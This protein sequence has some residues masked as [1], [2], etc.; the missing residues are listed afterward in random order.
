MNVNMNSLN[1]KL[2]KLSIALS[3]FG[4]REESK[5]VIGLY[6]YAFTKHAA[7]KK[8]ILIKK[9]GLDESIAEKLDKDFG[10][11][12]VWIL[13]KILE[14]AVSSASCLLADGGWST[15]VTT[16]TREEMILLIN[17][18]GPRWLYLNFGLQEI[19]DWITIGLNG[20]MSSVKDLKWNKLIEKAAEWHE[21][22]EGGV[23]AINYI[24]SNPIVLD[25]RD[26]DGI[27]FYWADLESRRS[28][29]EEER[30]GH[31]GIG[32]PGENLYSLREYKKAS[33]Q[34]FTFNKSHL[35]FSIDTNSGNLSQA[36]AKKNSK[37]S[38]SLHNYII[39]LLHLKRQRWLGPGDKKKLSF[40]YLIKT[41]ISDYKPET[42]FKVSDLSD[43]D[44]EKLFEKRKDLAEKDLIAKLKLFQRGWF[45]SESFKNKFVTEVEV[46]DAQY[47]D[48]GHYKIKETISE[49]EDFPIWEIP[50]DNAKYYLD[51]VDSEN[52]QYILNFI[53]KDK[54]PTPEGALHTW[55]DV[56]EDLND[57]YHDI[58]ID[59]IRTAEQLYTWKYWEYLREQIK[60]AAEEYGE[61]MSLENGFVK[62]KIKMRDYLSELVE[63]IDQ[64]SEQP[65]DA[66]WHTDSDLIWADLFNNVLLEEVGPVKIDI[67]RDWVP[68]IEE[69][70]FN[71]LLKEYVYND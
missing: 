58:A 45:D 63:S 4:H 21:Q 37:P 56:S 52:Q 13:N 40:E 10:G 27:G 54:G 69:K 55:S 49:E 17:E 24:E 36:K 7:S 70:E 47:F 8:K 3:S 62:I 30:M 53:N 68:H 28:K 14:S 22:L 25:F 51:Y 15:P 16:T 39:P 61:F 19:R 11:K 34:N 38:S 41:T 44:L 60:S 57:K 42:D 2:K 65:L 20:D 64:V 6:D 67:D 1:N 50:L 32:S 26:K 12:S 23:E 71:E 59:I 46:C 48:C 43:E 31:C 5:K 33:G 18:R 29:E 66:P 9:F 35:T